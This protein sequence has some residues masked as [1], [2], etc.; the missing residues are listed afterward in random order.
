MTV[1]M[2]RVFPYAEE[3]LSLL[4]TFS[5]CHPAEVLCALGKRVTVAFEDPDSATYGLVQFG[6]GHSRRCDH[7]PQ[8]DPMDHVTGEGAG[9]R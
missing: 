4:R 3:S 5:C 6:L 2:W 8:D 7:R 1:K 9:Q